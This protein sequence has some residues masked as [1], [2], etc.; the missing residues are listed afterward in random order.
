MNYPQTVEGIFL[1]RPN[2][3]VARVRVGEAVE[4]VHVKNTGR[5]RELLVPGTRVHLVPADLP[6]RKTKFD[7]VAVEKGPLS[8]LVNMD[9]QVPNQVVFEGLSQGL[10]PG[11]S[12]LRELKKE[13]AFGDSR[14]DLYYET[15]EAR[16]FIEVKGVTLEE[17]GVARFPDAPTQRGRKH[18]CGLAALQSQGYQNHVFFLVQMEGVHRFEPNRSTDPRFAE[19][20]LAAAEAGVRI[21][22][23]GSLVT[24]GSIRMG[25]PLP[26]VLA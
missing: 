8:L 6:H 24:P 4:T 14:Y 21:H 17:G 7:L 1:E 10:V 20:L 3:F 2:R 15:A 11:F 12:G 18:L 19:A 5:C 9:S 13:V 26:V 16:G 22:C 25:D 23:H